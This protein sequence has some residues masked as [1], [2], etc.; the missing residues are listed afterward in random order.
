MYN[1]GKLQVLISWMWHCTTCDGHLVS[2]GGRVVVRWW[3][4]GG[5][6]VVMQWSGGSHVVVIAVLLFSQ[7]HLSI[8]SGSWPP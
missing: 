5:H 4:C 3:P 1:V 8:L 7:Q 2:C 6:V